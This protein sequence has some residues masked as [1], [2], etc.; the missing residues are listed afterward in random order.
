M[1]MLVVLVLMQI[2]VLIVGR[3]PCFI[4]DECYRC[5]QAGFVSNSSF[6]GRLDPMS[7]R[8]RAYEIEYHLSDPRQRK[9]SASR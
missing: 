5:T 8:M 6:R 1:V 7:S 3:R 2:L 9:Y 4:L